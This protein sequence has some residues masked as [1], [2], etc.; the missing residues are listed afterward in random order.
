NRLWGHFFGI[1]VVEPVDDFSDEHPPS[2]P[3]VL[4]ELAKGFV[5][6]GFDLKFL[7]K[8]ITLTEAYGRSSGSG[9]SFDV[10]LFAS[11]PVKGLT[12][13]QIFDSLVQ[14]TGMRDTSSPRDRQFFGFSTPR[15]DFATK[16]ELS[17]KRT[18]APTTI[19]QALTLMNG[20]VTRDATSLEGSET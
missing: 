5:R 1:G 13:E 19:L 14:A 7:M 17:G 6:S 16:F 4:D 2:H 12:G 18:E 20:E 15:N 10:R 9:G 8:A 11:M 3:E